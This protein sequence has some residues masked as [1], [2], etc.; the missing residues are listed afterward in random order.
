MKRVYSVFD[1]VALAYATLVV[2]ASDAPA[3]RSFSDA[4]LDPK[5]PWASHPADYELHCLGEMT[6]TFD[7]I[8]DVKNVLIGTP[9]RVV[10]TGEAV[11]AQMARG[12]ELARE[13]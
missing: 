6:D 13:A 7:H 11:A 10:V 4:L 8:Q 1:R 3:V 2:Y 5:S 12:P 9:W